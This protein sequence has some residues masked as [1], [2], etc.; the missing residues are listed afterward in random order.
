MGRKKRGDCVLPLSDR[1]RALEILWTL[2]LR[3]LVTLVLSL[4]FTRCWD[5][6]VFGATTTSAPLKSLANGC[7]DKSAGSKA[8]TR[9]LA[10]EVGDRCRVMGCGWPAAG[11]GRA[12]T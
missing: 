1:F 6:L 11:F 10:V 8:A 7:V 4:L 9:I 5:C 12:R 2:V 3:R